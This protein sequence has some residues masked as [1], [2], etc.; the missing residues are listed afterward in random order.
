MAILAVG[1]SVPVAPAAS[2]SVHRQPAIPLVS[3]RMAL[4]ADDPPGYAGAGHLVQHLLLPTLRTQ[5]ER[6]GG[7]VEMERT[8]DA[9]VYTLTGPSREL[10]FLADVLRA[11]LR[12][13][14]PTAGAL[15]RAS[16][17][18]A[19]E[20]LEEWE[21][22]D[23]HVRSVLRGQLFPGDLSAAGTE[24][25]A[26]RFEAEEIPA[27]WRRMY[28]PARLSILAVGDVTMSD[29]QAA[30]S[31]LPDRATV[32]DDDEGDAPVDTV[33]TVPL[34]PAEATRGWL[35]AGYLASDLEPAAVSV[36]ARIIQDQLREQ[37]PDASVSAEHWW[38]HDGQA[39]ALIV[40]AP[41]PRIAAAR[42]ALNTLASSI[43]T[44]LTATRVHDAARALRRE[45]LFYAR[46]PERMSEVVGRFSD[47]DGD[48]EAADRFYAS[49][50]EVDLEAVRDVLGHMLEH[51]PARVEIAAPRPKPAG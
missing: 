21:S 50:D 38:T 44:R 12:P 17:E 40:G 15:L 14:A 42:R 35:G 37:L 39:L 7:A 6:V 22:A 5:V 2:F 26:A 30:F 16:R 8:S 3:L 49:L 47:R 51:T 9:V 24:R 41:A 46:T 48:P 29:L 1:D 32:R 23:Q 10:P 18:L 20:R 19:E 11:A 4:L 45:M 27:I 36:A 34:A 13:A 28:D 43:D 31:G 25:S 33:S